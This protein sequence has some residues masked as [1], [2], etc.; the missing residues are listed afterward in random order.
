MKLRL[1]LF[2]MLI[3]LSNCRKDNYET[4]QTNHLLD[5]FTGGYTPI[6]SV[7]L[8]DPYTYIGS[9]TSPVQFS[10]DRKGHIDFSHVMLKEI[11]HYG[12]AVY[13]IAPCSFNV[14]ADVSGYDLSFSQS[15]TWDCP[16]QFVPVSG[17]SGRLNPDTTF[18]ICYTDSNKYYH[19]FYS[20]HKR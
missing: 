12:P 20:G 16:C 11:Y 17:I 15:V 1:A 4:I 9:G 5:A 6:D 2:T 3:V 14:K 13:D 10:H 7:W 8:I 18:L 19:K